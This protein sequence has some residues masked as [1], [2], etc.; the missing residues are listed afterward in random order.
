MKRRQRQLAAAVARAG[1]PHPRPRTGTVAPTAITDDARNALAKIAASTVHHD[2]LVA[3][4]ATAADAVDSPVADET[5]PVA[6]LDIPVQ[7][8]KRA[9]RKVNPAAAE[10]IPRLG[11]RGPSPSPSEPG[12]GRSRGSR[13][14]GSAG[15]IAECASGGVGARPLRPGGRAGA[16][17]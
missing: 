4:P 3:A 12:Q 16:R 15:Q 9:P 10:E 14:A 13:R 5:G 6:I 17:Y 2:E 8:V 11:A 7:K 1:R